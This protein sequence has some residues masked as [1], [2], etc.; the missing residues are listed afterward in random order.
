MHFSDE[1]ECWENCNGDRLTVGTYVKATDYGDYF[2]ELTGSKYMV[3]AIEFNEK[4][5]VVISINDGSI[6]ST[7]THKSGFKICDLDPV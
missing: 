3:T 5:E 1:M 7:K 6:Q 2:D 4:D